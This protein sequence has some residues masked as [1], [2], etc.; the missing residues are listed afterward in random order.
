MAF[1]MESIEAV[2]PFN[3]SATARLTANA[4]QEHRGS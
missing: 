4:D 2:L 3:A 1:A